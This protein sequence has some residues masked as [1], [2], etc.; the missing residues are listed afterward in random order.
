VFGVHAE[1]ALMSAPVVM[2]EWLEGVAAVLEG[3]MMGQ[4]GGEAIADILYGKVNPSGKLAETFPLRL[5]DIPTLINWP[6]DSGQVQVWRRVVYW[7]SILRCQRTPG[8]VPLW[9]WI[10]LH[11]VCI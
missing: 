11:H 4:A 1:T 2:N 5:A 7:L 3:Y 10:E 8:F 6:G 9:L